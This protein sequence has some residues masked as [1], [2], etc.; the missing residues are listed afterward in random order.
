MRIAIVHGDTDSPGERYPLAREWA[1]QGDEVR[2]TPPR[3][4]DAAGAFGPQ[5]VITASPRLESVTAARR[6]ARRARCPLVFELQANWTDLEA[7]DRGK[8]Q[9]QTRKAMKLA[10]GKSRRVVSLLPEG[11]A[12]LEALG[13]RGRATDCLPLVP[14]PQPGERELDPRHLAQLQQLRQGYDFLVL[15]E[16]D[17]SWERGLGRLI[18]AAKLL[19]ES[20]VAVALVG[21]GRHSPELKRRM[22]DRTAANVYL[23][24]PVVPEQKAAL[25]RHADCLF[26]G[27][28]RA[29]AVRYG[30]VD[31]GLLERMSYGRP[32]VTA[33][34]A[35]GQLPSPVVQ[36][37]CGLHA[38]EPDAVAL[39][40]TLAR[41]QAMTPGQRAAM[42]ERGRAFVHAHHDPREVS[43]A[44]RRLLE[45]TVAEK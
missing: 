22:L 31:P 3:D 4:L 45:E 6:L 27:E 9:R 24:D 13:L 33:F 41:L 16:G 11:P 36:A 20:R 1:A 19:E 21:E 30:V 44:Y 29:P 2:M 39:A 34:E 37:D 25:Y 38:G 26:Y 15:Y 8:P 10:V 17:F 18:D 35:P 5:V 12:Y 7:E 23:L 32:V 43:R 42:G 40:R 28:E 14:D